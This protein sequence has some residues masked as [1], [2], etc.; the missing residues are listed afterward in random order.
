MDHWPRYTTNT[1]AHFLKHQA[2]I[3]TEVMP[4]LKSVKFMRQWAGLTDMTPDMAPILDGNAHVKGYF[5]DVGWGYFGFKSGPV[6]GRYMAEFIAT[7]QKPG[8]LEPFRLDRF[9]EHCFI[10][11]TTRPTYYGPWN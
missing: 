5:M 8:I 3:M 2:E 4:C 11:E 7:N 1:S 9:K 6:A 10:G